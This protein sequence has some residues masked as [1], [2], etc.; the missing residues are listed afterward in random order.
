MISYVGVPLD[1]AVSWKLVKETAHKAILS[2]WTFIPRIIKDGLIIG[3]A[4]V[5]SW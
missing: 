4:P 1:I 2:E 3:L 5:R